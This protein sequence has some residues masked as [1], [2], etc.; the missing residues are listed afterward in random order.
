M[1]N[2][3]CEMLINAHENIIL[4]NQS[5]NS[6]DVGNIQFCDEQQSQR[7]AS[8]LIPD[9]TDTRWA[10]VDFIYEIHSNRFRA[11]QSFFLII[12]FT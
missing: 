3:K 12:E 9:S 10:N 11:D 7:V 5:V 8:C 1:T 6:V 2:E 4:S